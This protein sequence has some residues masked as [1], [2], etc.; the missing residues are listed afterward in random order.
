MPPPVKAWRSLKGRA[1]VFAVAAFVFGIGALSLYT[2]RLLYGDTVRLLGEQQFSVVTAV[3]QNVNDE[4]TNHLLALETVANDMDADL[5]TRRDALQAR[6][7]Q[8]SLLQILFNGGVFVTNKDG[9]V[10]A[11]LPLSAQRLDFDYKD[12]DFIAAVLKDGKPTIGRPVMGRA[13]RSPVFAIS[14]PVRDAQGNTIGVLVGATDLGKPN[15]LDKLTTPPY[16]QA[17]GYILVEPRTRQIITA[18]DK[19][20]IMEPLPAPDVHSFVDRN[21]AGYE[22]YSVLVNALGEEQLASVKRIPVAGWYMLLGTPTS[23]AFA[24]IHNL[25]Q[26]LLWVT[27]LLTLLAGALTW[28]FF[29]RQFLPLT[30]TVGA[31][32]ALSDSKQIPSP[33]P[34]HGGDEIALLV[35]GFNRL[36]QTWTER[37][38]LLK[39]N[40]QNLA[41]TLHSIGDGVIATDVAGRVTRMNPT[42]QRLTGWA[43]DEALGRPLVEVFRIVNATTRATVSDPVQ[44]V[45]ARGEVVGL[46][47]H[48][49]LIAHD[50]REYQIADSAAPI[51]DDA[52]QIVGVV[53]VFSDVS[54][55]YAVQE[56]LDQFF[57]QTQHLHLVA[58]FDGVIQ[59]V[60]LGW[61]AL[62]GYAKAELEGG[63][64]LSLVHP[65]DQAS[66]MAEVAKL[67]Q[68]A[69]T[70]HFENRYRH[71]NGEYRVMDWSASVSS[72]GQLIYAVAS[73][74]TEQKRAQRYDQFRSRMLELVATNEPLAALLE[75]IAL[76]VEK[77]HPGMLC[78]VLLLDSSGRCFE[79][80]V[81]PSLPDFYSGAF[82]GVEIGVGV[83]SCGTAAATGERVIVSDIATHAYWAQYKDLAASAGLAACWSQPIRGAG[84]RVLGTFAIYHRVPQSPAQVDIDLIELTANLTSIAI[85]RKRAEDAM[86]NRQILLER[87]ESLARMASFEWDV[88]TNTTTWSPEMFRIFGRDPVLGVP[89]LQGQSE[90]F[91]PESAQAL[92]DVVGKAVSAGVP[93][94]LELLAVQPDGQQ[95]PCWVQGFPQRNASGRVVRIAGLVQDITARKLSENKQQ[96]AASVFTH[97]RE[98]ITITDADG[99]I[100]DVNDMFT[101]IAGYSR[102]EVLGKNPRFLQSGRQGKAFYDALWHDLTT[103]GHWS[104]EI[105]NRRKNGEVYPETLTISAV[106]DAQGKTQHY[107]ALS[108]DITAA[109]EHEKQLEHI[110]HYDTLT[111]LPNRLL[112]SDRLTQAITHS[113]RRGNALAVVYLDLDNIK[114][115][116]DTY[117]HEAGDAVLTG[118]SDA[119]LDVLRDGDTLARL[120]GD[121]F[122]AVLVD[123]DQTGDC[124]PV[125]ERLLQA[126]ATAITLPM[127][128]E[129][130]DSAIGESVQVSASIGVTF[131]PQDDV[132]ADVLLRHADQAMYQAKQTGKNRYHLFDIAQDVAIQT[133]HEDLKHIRQALA[134][135]EF[136]L[137]YQPK[138]NMRTG[139]V[140]G[141]EALIRWQHPARGLLPPGAFLHIFEGHE[142]SIDVG[143]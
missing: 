103:Q 16:G 69:M 66:T 26:R 99:N 62:L 8:R 52:G 27:L 95:L 128:A 61:E 43:L 132:V 122:V 93:Y 104:G 110:A 142:L 44:L 42:A 57:E 138:V 114:A 20:R 35:G 89:N 11:D 139:K 117:G 13:L 12:R 60:N 22:G 34:V 126:A 71:K 72:G 97:A 101:Q 19:K 50:G 113:Q 65:D 105:W 76:G 133:H 119:M 49:T 15:F 91:T 18:T 37:E 24:P 143:E 25:Q 129:V 112:L 85:E 36:L 3:A 102:D 106:R 5:L 90:L 46:A 6:L 74:V 116:N 54:E 87:T 84:G 111:G 92:F 7:A 56:A 63:N 79:Q 94:E 83:G 30:K 107:V 118:L 53:L 32:R 64:F 124:I 10:I 81:A 51:R 21:I 29:N 9:T 141:A 136:V 33:L 131:Y 2:N 115:I 58:R 45:M 123:L 40:Q 125:I 70:F 134:N 127:D 130:G 140:I 23:E 108:S 80:C 47:N 86:Q 137:H 48:T 135:H 41:I 68:G 28:W 14:V 1:T 121:E 98:A 120:G 96:L 82:D 88:D 67:S 77:L 31:M 75:A 59:R 109:K 78:G 73:D 55:K 100:I 39:E 17:G 38:A 4:L